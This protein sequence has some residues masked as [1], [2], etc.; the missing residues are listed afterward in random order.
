MRNL[1]SFSLVGGGI[2]DILFCNVFGEI[3]IFN[4]RYISIILASC[5]LLQDCLDRHLY[6]ED[7]IQSKNQPN[8]LEQFAKLRP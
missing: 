4:L 6:T 5:Y 7:E 1:L 8:M 3:M 2:Y